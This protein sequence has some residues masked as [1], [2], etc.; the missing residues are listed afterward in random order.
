MN[1][2]LRL[3]N[4]KEPK[5]NSFFLS[6]EKELQKTFFF[7]FDL[8]NRS[9]RPIDKRSSSSVPLGKCRH[10]RLFLYC[11][12]HLLLAARH[13]RWRV[14]NISPSSM[15]WRTRSVWFGCWKQIRETNAPQPPGNRSRTFPS[16]PAPRFFFLHFS[17]GGKNTLRPHEEPIKFSERGNS[18]CLPLSHLSQP[19]IIFEQTLNATPRTDTMARTKQ[20]ARKSTGGKA[21]RKQLATKVRY[22]H[23]SQGFL[24]LPTSFLFLPHPFFFSAHSLTSRDFFSFFFAVLPS[25]RCSPSTRLPASP[26]PPR[27]A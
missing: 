18:F 12:P 27:V 17:C 20:T 9:F 23:D 25:L 10:G 26:P 14:G 15:V 13:I 11:A 24:H 22:R 4:P 3:R 7:S 2:G 21:P 5:K 19:L 16:L 8:R 6:G 1:L